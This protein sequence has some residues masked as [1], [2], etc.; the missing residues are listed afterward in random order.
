MRSILARGV[1]VGGGHEAGPADRGSYRLLV[2]RVRLHD[3]RYGVDAAEG[4][5]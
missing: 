2:G 3:D 5:S 1:H 4:D